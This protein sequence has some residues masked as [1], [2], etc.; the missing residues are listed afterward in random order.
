MRRLSLGLVLLAHLC[1]AHAGCPQVQSSDPYPTV[2]A[3]WLLKNIQTEPDSLEG[4]AVALQGVVEEVAYGTTHR[5][6]LKIGL[7]GALHKSI[8]LLPFTEPGEYKFAP[9]ETRVRFM[10]WLRYTEEMLKTEAPEEIAKG[11]KL[12]VMTLCLIRAPSGD[13]RFSSK[14]IEKCR[15]WEHRELPRPLQ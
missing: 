10:G 8:W 3:E 14:W 7:D 2:D 15:A 6:A 9:P 11:P 5:P 1:S 13:A 4:C 12:A